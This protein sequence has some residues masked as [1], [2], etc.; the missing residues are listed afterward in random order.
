MQ[1]HAIDLW[2]HGHVHSPSD[3]TVPGTRTR[4]LCN[5]R[6]YHGLREVSGFSLARCVD[7]A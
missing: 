7:L 6:G 4:V 1:R 2:F 5:P 3:Y